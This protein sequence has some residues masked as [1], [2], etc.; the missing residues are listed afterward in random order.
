[1]NNFLRRISMKS[2]IGLTPR[3]DA[4][5]RRLSAHY[6]IG[7]HYKRIYHY[8]IRKTGGTSINQ[9]FLG[10]AGVPGREVYA[11][12]SRSFSLRMV[13]NDKVFVGWN[14]RLIEQGHYYYAF[15]HMPLHQI[16]IPDNT[17]TITC[18]REPVGRL[19]SHYK[20]LLDY[21]EAGVTRVDLK[22]ELGWLGGSFSYFV[23]NLPRRHLQRQLYMF[24]DRYDLAEALDMV[25]NCSCV[26][27]THTLGQD[28]NKLAQRL[29]LN[30][31]L[32]HTR[33][34][35]RNLRLSEGDL[36]LA[37]T[38]LE[39]ELRWYEEVEKQKLALNEGR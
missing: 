32:E 3:E 34:S 38:A 33:R 21:Q 17:F 24:S 8:H 12:I 16:S 39:P 14:R 20:M 10:L 35:S 27:F 19:L 13:V 25:M 31:Q 7:S 4:V 23:S 28:A 30:L 15:S 5:C 29:K 9:M 11:G 22:E 36:E 18:L 2:G 26:L 1:M 6:E 37:H